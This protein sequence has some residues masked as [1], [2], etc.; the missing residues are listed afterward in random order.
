MEATVEDEAYDALNYVSLPEN[1]SNVGGFT[2]FNFCYFHTMMLKFWY[3]YADGLYST[4]QSLQYI[5][6]FMYK[7]HQL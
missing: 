3:H 5:A 7:F 2:G 4:D 1:S 6:D